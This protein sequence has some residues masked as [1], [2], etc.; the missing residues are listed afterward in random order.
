MYKKLLDKGFERTV[1]VKY[2]DNKV[3]YKKDFLNPKQV[4][5]LFEYFGEDKFFYEKTQGKFYCTLEIT[6]DLSFAQ[7]CFSQLRENEDDYMEF[8]HDDLN[9][10]EFSKALDLL[11]DVVIIEE[12]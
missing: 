11:D 1:Y 4:N 7:Y 5:E 12:E 2:E 8:V 3:F 10:E 6:E 9:L